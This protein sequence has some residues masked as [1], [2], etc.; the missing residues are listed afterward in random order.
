[1]SEQKT[2][3]A[4]EAGVLAVI[5]LG[6]NLGDSA[7]TLASA[8]EQI[9]ATPEITHVALSST[10]TSRPAVIAEQPNFKNAVLLIRT[11][12]SPMRLLHILQG[13]ETAFGRIREGIEYVPYGPR[14]L[15]LDIIDIEG[16]VCHGPDLTL[17]HPEALRRAFVVTPLLEISPHHVLADAT[18]VNTSRVEC[19]EIIDGP[20]C[21]KEGE[22]GEE[23][24][25]GK[26]ESS[27]SVGKLS[28]CATP[29]GNLGDITLRVLQ[30]LQA[31]DV[32]Y[33]EDTRVTRRLTT[34][35]QIQTPLRRADAHR[36]PALL[37]AMLA[38]LAAGRHLAYVSDAGMP[39]ISDPGSLLVATVREAG[40]TVEILPGAS[41][42]TT[43]LAA[44]GIKAHSSYFGGF[45]PRKSGAGMRLL[46][47]L[48]QLEGTTL[49]FY[50]SVYRTAKTLQLIA[51]VLPARTVVMA[52]ELTKLYEEVLTGTAGELVELLDKRSAEG[53]KLKGE[54]VLLIAPESS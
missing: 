25:S 20:A 14:T 38:E 12:L 21:E 10:Y 41:A 15:D 37:P 46:K 7:A 2:G 5:A 40:Y 8:A 39:G 22:S 26:G 28:V 16:V 33:C 54:I 30:T 36:L 11:T 17:P 29:I 45:F 47:E 23:Y 51:E 34:Q 52:R 13:I 18:V 43:A 1:M 53:R 24:E 49:V 19:G 42:L 44:A 48:E 27:G 50:E 4:G 6:S 35:Y 32:I 3:G 31:A 9:A